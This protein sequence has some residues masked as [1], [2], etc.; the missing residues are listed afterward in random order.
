MRPLASIRTSKG[1]PYRC[2]FCALWKLTG[3]RY[4]RR[5]PERIV[6]ELAG[7][8]E[9][10]VFFADDESLVDAPRMHA[11]ARLIKHAGIRKRYFLYGRPDTI[12][13]NRDL[14]ASWKDVGL[15][16]VFVGF[17]SWRDDDLQRIRKGS[18]TS[19]NVAAARLL[20][21]LGI[22]M[23][24]SFIVRPEFDKEDFAALRRYCRALDLRFVGFAVLTPLPGTDYY[25]QVKDALLT[26]EPAYF[27]FIHTVL[28]TKLPLED[29]YSEYTRLV[30]GAVSPANVMSFLGKFAWKDLPGELAKGYRFLG[31]ARAAH[32]DYPT[33]SGWT[34]D[35]VHHERS[36]K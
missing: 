2:N 32:R 14:L 33:R 13:R 21:D 34:S 23:R 18:C 31:R 12:A 4:L 19:D 16:R 26:H 24:A 27:D 22:D 20:N 17:E 7:I 5:A 35:D 10:Y 9:D 1:C 8:Q 29:F 11:L 30:I 15:E 25:D 36:V 6:E 28:P 3:G